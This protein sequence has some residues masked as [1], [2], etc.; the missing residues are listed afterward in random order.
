MEAFPNDI[1][2]SRNQ[3]NPESAGAHDAI[4]TRKGDRRLRVLERIRDL[5]TKGGN[6]WEIAQ[7][8]GIE[9]N[10]ISGRVTELLI[11]RDVVDSHI[12]RP[13]GSGL[14][15]RVVIAV[16][17]RPALIAEL[18]GKAVHATDVDEYRYLMGIAQQLEEDEKRVIEGEDW[19]AQIDESY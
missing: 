3:G 15:A 11:T 16:E 14:M 13:T 6:T 19:E 4:V 7:H 17:H 8:W 5:G 9:S 12:R 18:R 1:C 2:L 10:A